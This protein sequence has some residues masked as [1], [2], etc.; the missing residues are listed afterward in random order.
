MS[1]QWAAGNKHGGNRL[2][3]ENE[4]VAKKGFTSITGMLK[5]VVF[6]VALTIYILSFG[7]QV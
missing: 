7:L 5:V 6:D 3:A 1:Q 2:I 4:F